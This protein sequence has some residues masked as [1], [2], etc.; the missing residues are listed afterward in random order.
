MRLFVAALPSR[1]VVEDLEEFLEPRWAAGDP[2]LRWALPEQ[3]HLTLAFLPDVADRDLEELEDSLGA[4]C[5]RFA[6]LRLR[7]AGAGAFPGPIDARVLWLGV[8]GSD[9]ATL[10]RVADATRTAAGRAGTQVDGR[11]FVAHITL[12]RY[13]RAVDATRWLRVLDTYDGLPWTATEVRLVRSF[14][15]QGRGGHP[16]Y[17]TLTRLSLGARARG[18]SLASGE[19][20]ARTRFS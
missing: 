11:R 9:D 2:H 16:R 18:A 14:L 1:E 6:P 12:G 19:V 13:R 17:E 8:R 20:R 7:L 15:G 3:W 4:A 10:R 5:A